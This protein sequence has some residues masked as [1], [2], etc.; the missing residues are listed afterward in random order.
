MSSSESEEADLKPIKSETLEQQKP[1]PNAVYH[2][3]L[4]ANNKFTEMLKNKI[5]QSGISPI[6]KIKFNDSNYDFNPV[7]SSTQIGTPNEVK[8]GR[9]SLKHNK[10]SS[11]KDSS[12]E[13]DT[14]KSKIIEISSTVAGNTTSSEDSD[15]SKRK[16]G[17]KHSIKDDASVKSTSNTDSDDS[18]QHNRHVKSKKNNVQEIRRT[19]VNTTKTKPKKKKVDSSDSETETMILPSRKKT[20]KRKSSS[21]SE[22]EEIMSKSI[23]QATRSSSSSEKEETE[24]AKSGSKNLKKDDSISSSESDEKNKGK[25]PQKRIKEKKPLKTRKSSSSSYSSGD[26]FV[27]QKVKSQIGS[28]AERLKSYENES[29]LQRIRDMNNFLKKVKPK[30]EL[31]LLQVPIKLDPNALVGINISLSEQMR[32]PQHKK[33]E[34]VPSTKSQE[35]ISLFCNDDDERIHIV[36]PMGYINIQRHL[37]KQSVGNASGFKDNPV[38]FPS[39][40]KERHPLFGSDFTNKINLEENIKQKLAAA[41]ESYNRKKKKEAKEKKKTL[42]TGDNQEEEEIFKFLSQTSDG[43]TS[44]KANNSMNETYSEFELDASTS[45][46]CKK[47]KKKK[48]K[49]HRSVDEEDSTSRKKRKKEEFDTDVKETKAEKF[50][51]P[52]ES[53][54]IEQLLFNETETL[55]KKKKK[56]KKKS[57]VEDE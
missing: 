3:F 10:L 28:P 30:E 15:D 16:K 29:S 56:K 20:H 18:S 13:E 4:N 17:Q 55:Y 31:F 25:R 23:V 9:K 34:S 39:D 41:V 43:S 38:L 48:D 1:A 5:K 53:S 8:H 49:R 50:E 14:N 35:T 2:N 32:I 44:K 33:Y 57:E 36:K 24:N 22:S 40:L 54:L 11:Y 12:S 52:N 51:S 26:E 46:G 19:S 47:K 45:Y 37:K 27:A 6:S 42:S 7:A 21:S